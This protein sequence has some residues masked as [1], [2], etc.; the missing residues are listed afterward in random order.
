MDGCEAKWP[1]RSL[2]A[3]PLVIWWTLLVSWGVSYLW[4]EVNM[5]LIFSINNGQ[6]WSV[7]RPSQFHLVIGHFEWSVHNLCL[8]TCN[9]HWVLSLV[10]M[11]TCWP[12]E[13]PPSRESSGQLYVTVGRCVMSLVISELSSVFPLFP[14]LSLVW[15]CRSFGLLVISG[16]L[17]YLLVIF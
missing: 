6:F 8:V 5:Q 7:L 14:V 9:G 2:P 3:W 10:I 4:V 12:S 16:D 15:F 1:W 17:S 13:S 11:V